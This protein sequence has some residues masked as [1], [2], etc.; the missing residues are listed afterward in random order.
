MDR[1]FKKII[2]LLSLFILAFV[3][4]INNDLS[5]QQNVKILADKMITDKQK[6]FIEASGDVLIINED[7]TKINAE[8]VLYDNK[9]N[10]VTADEDV[11][12]L[13]A[14]GNYYF[15]S[16]V[17]TDKSLNN[18]VGDNVKSECQMDQE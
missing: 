10:R 15:M 13:D 2:L 17:I 7:G 16:R 12:V 8:N 1:T 5:A 3:L 11:V 18:L 4:F 9:N 6:D 14:E